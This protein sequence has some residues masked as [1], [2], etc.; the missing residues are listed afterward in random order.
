M[1][2]A[3][4]KTVNTIVYIKELGGGMVDGNPLVTPIPGTKISTASTFMVSWPCWEHFAHILNRL[5][6]PKPATTQL[7]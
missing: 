2:G 7:S 4:S 1:H 3:S 6:H 5:A